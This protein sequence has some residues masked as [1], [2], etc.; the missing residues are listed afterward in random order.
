MSSSPHIDNKKKYIWILGK[1]PTQ[2]LENTLTTEKKFS[3]NCAEHNKKICL[4]LHYRGANS[5][6]FVNGTEIITFKAKDSEKLDVIDMFMIL[7][8]IMMLM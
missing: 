2:G 3:I 4:S 8:L 1:G 5:Y 6:L 7:A